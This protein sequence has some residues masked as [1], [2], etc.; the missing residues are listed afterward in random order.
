M[1]LDVDT[2][3]LSWRVLRKHIVVNRNICKIQNMRKLRH[4]WHCRWFRSFQRVPTLMTQK[5]QWL[6]YPGSAIL[7]CSL[8]LVL[9][10]FMS[11]TKFSNFPLAHSICRHTIG[12]ELQKLNVFSCPFPCEVQIIMCII[13]LLKIYMPYRRQAGHI[14]AWLIILFKVLISCLLFPY[15]FRFRKQIFS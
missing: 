7:L 13:F 2:E 11:G 10:I 6:S 1:K 8:S 4:H 12:Q 5:L 15:W 3:K 9:C 14:T